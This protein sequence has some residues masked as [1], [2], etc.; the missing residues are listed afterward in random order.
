MNKLFPALGVIALAFATPL[1]ASVEDVLPTKGDDISK[2]RDAGAWTIRKNATSGSCFASYKA[3]SGAIVQFGFVKDETAGYL[4][5]FSE[6]VGAVKSEQDVAFIANGNL[7]S[8]KATGVGSS[9]HDG[10]QGGYVVVNNP[11]FVKDIEAG[12]ELVVFPETPQTYI[13]DM[14]GASAAVYEVRKC[15]TELGS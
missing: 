4:G 8:G 3:E 5:I 9:I 15:T 10:Y 7:Y 13:V 14:S 1:L 11:K 6:N 2:V 12:G